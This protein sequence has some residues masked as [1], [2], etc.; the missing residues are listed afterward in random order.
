MLYLNWLCNFPYS[1]NVQS[2]IVLFNHRPYKLW[3]FAVLVVD[4]VFPMVVQELMNI[5]GVGSLLTW[6]P[7]DYI[8]PWPY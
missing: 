3:F 7:T 2:K 8:N 1:Q 5:E 6:R 4:W